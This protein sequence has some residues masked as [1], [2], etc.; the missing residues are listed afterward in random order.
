MTR[1]TLLASFAAA[2]AAAALPAAAQ[3]GGHD[4]AQHDQAKQRS[5]STLAAAGIAEGTLEKGVRTFE[6]AVTEDGF[7]PAK[8]KA[9]KGEKVRLVVTRRTDRTCATEIVIPSHKVNQPLPLDKAVTVLL[10]P[11]ASGE[12][13]FACGM[14]HVSGVLFVP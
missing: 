1:R 10:T 2:L 14:D 13:R 8:L 5:A 11:K 7:V 3:H 12:I 9:N 6:I 4:H